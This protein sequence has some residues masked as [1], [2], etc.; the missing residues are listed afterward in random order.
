MIF[1]RNESGPKRP[2]PSW[3]IDPFHEMV[4]NDPVRNDPDSLR[5]IQT[6]E[7]RPY[8]STDMCRLECMLMYVGK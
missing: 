2:T 5:P 8:L 4:R 6:K 7:L 1:G 3:R